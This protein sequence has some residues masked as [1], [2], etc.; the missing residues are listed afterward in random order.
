MEQTTMVWFQKDLRIHFHI[1][2][3]TFNLQRTA[4]CGV[5]AAPFFCKV[6]PIL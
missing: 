5:D 1:A 2:H 6:H 3:D 4:V